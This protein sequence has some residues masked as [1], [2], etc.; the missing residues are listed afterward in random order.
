MNQLAQEAALASGKAK[1]RSK[2]PQ[3]AVDLLRERSEEIRHLI[4]AGVEQ[5]DR[6]EGVSAEE[7][8]AE[9]ERE[10]SEIIARAKQR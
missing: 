10:A 4:Q 2:L 9:L 8:F 1:K 5:L 7:V 6:G 3:S